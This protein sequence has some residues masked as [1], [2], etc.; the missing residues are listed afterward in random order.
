MGAGRHATAVASV[1]SLLVAVESAAWPYPI[2][3]P[4]TSDDGRANPPARLSTTRRAPAV[5][6]VSRYAAARHRGGGAA[7]WRSGLGA[8]LHVLLERALASAGQRLQRLP[9]GQL[10]APARHTPTAHRA[11]EAAWSSLGQHGATHVVIHP[12]AY[13]DGNAR[14]DMRWL[15]HTA[16]DS[17]SSSTAITSS[18]FPANV[19][20]DHP[21][22]T[23]V[24]VIADVRV[25]CTHYVWF[26]CPRP[27]LCRTKRR[28]RAV[29]PDFLVT[30]SSSSSWCRRCSTAR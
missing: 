27:A 6:R 17:S 28:P 21:P 1:L 3:R 11:P 26:A 13:S 4:M 25:I 5:Y 30:S 22:G 19:S 14:E 24:E 2:N 8:P 7:V 16:P 18:K 10:R 15:S 29:G 20:T 23:E 12:A 9:P